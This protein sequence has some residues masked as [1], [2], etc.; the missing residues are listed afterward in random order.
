[1]VLGLVHIW[2]AVVH[3]GRLSEKTLP[4]ASKE[5]HQFWTKVLLG[6]VQAQAGGLITKLTI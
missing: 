1:M 6:A 2:V 3:G 4:C 5:V